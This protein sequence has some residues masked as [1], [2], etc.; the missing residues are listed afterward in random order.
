MSDPTDAV[1]EPSSRIRQRTWDV[2]IS[3][4]HED[5]AI[6]GALGKAIE[7]RGLTTWLDAKLEAG[8]SL[9]A[10]ERALLSSGALIV[11]LSTASLSS[12]WVE[13]EIT[14]AL[15]MLPRNAVFPVAVGEVDVRTA[16]R[17]L[18]TRK[19]LYLR[20]SRRVDRL[21]DRLLPA[22]DA[23]L[24]GHTS[25]KETVRITGD[26][27][28]RTPL[29][30]VDEYLRRLQGQQTGMTWIVG[31]P[32]TGKTKLAREYAFQIR[33]DVDFISWLSGT[34]T[35]VADLERHL[36]QTDHQS[37]AEHGLVVLDGYDAVEGGRALH[38]LLGAIARRHRV[39]ITA[40][41]LTDSTLVNERGDTVLMVGPLSHA[42][43]VEY[44]DT[45]AS[46]LSPDER[47]E[48]A[49]VAVSTGGSPLTLR[50]LTEAI[51]SQSFG[52]VMSTLKSPEMTVSRSLQVLLDQL[53]V[54]QRHRLDVLSFCSGL[55]ST[56]RTD[57]R[58]RLPGDDALFARLNDF[59][60]CATEAHGTVFMHRL[61]VAFLRRNAP[62]QA[63]RDAFAY[64]APR[65]PDPNDPDAQNYLSSVAELTEVA[66][67]DWSPDAAADLAELL[68]WQASAWRATGEPE[69]AEMLSPR[70][71]GLAAESGRVLLQIRALNLQSALAFDQ[72]RIDEASDIERRTAD[73]ALSALGPEHPISIASLANLATSRRAQGDL[74]EAITLLRRVVALGQRTLPAEHPDL[75]TAQV[76][77][78]I[79]L[80][81]AGL[82]EE[83]LLLLSET[84]RLI[85]DERVRLQVNQ[86]V[87]A[88]LM[89]LGR[90]EDAL[91]LL[92]ATLDR[93]DGIG[94][95]DSTDVLT[96]RANL[97]TIYARAGRLTEALALQGE[98]VGQLDV[99]HGPDHPVTLSARNNYAALLAQTGSV[100]DA[101]RLFTNVAI[102][103]ARV[104]GTDHPETL[105]S[106]LRVALATSE[107]GDSDHAFDMY[108]D[109][110]PR[111]V[112]IFGPDHPT[113]FTVRE[114]L[115]RELRRTGDTVG[116][117]L[118]FRE[119]L[120]DLERALPPEHPMTRRVESVLAEDEQE[121]FGG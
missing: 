23:A 106:W 53:A 11:L 104:L 85:T 100:E 76:N 119:L 102:S 38:P 111:L 39:V 84:E 52:T 4:A 74:P 1:R 18:A 107:Q 5:A 72:G 118:A 79:C 113:I 43:I 70:A 29:V 27:P 71:L 80:R 61:V 55:L 81:D 95:S 109:L 32:G 108:S 44:F 19:W 10:I 99:I 56:V 24:G 117:R 33:N 120:A 7:E 51:R 69:R 47:A 91:A 3:Y 17:W 114:G 20:D 68:I 73:L 116:A 50:V 54:D 6:A 60:L 88:V 16:P 57:K 31:Q 45:F 49:R 12:P 26:L 94:L 86:I 83:A 34:F 28:P 13:R 35:G 59:G 48:L 2:F 25:G 58:W 37:A 78:A 96:A 62:R 40:R 112:R 14:L 87:A 15:Q 115:A 77:L 101:S 89:D 103:R 65:L 42:D 97:A 66:E 75:A 98:I 93:T 105:L 92:V 22:L 8:E 63:I 9:H 90:L 41:H 36:R 110:L 121:P 21:V 46:E 82:A 64:V 30:G 67:L